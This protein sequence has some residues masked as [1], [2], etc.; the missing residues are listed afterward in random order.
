[1]QDVQT[2]HILHVSSENKKQHVPSDDKKQYSKKQY[3]L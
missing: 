2:K 1:M 3:M